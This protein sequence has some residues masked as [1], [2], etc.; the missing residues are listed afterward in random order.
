MRRAEF[1]LARVLFSVPWRGERLG[2]VLLPGGLFFIGQFNIL[3]GI[4]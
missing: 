4:N 3:E 2:L 1:I